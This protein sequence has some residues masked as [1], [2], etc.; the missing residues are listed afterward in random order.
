MT[1]HDDEAFAAQR[2]Q[3]ALILDR[4]AELDED[5]DSSW[6][7]QVLTEA[8]QIIERRRR[9]Y[10]DAIAAGVTPCPAAWSRTVPCVHPG[11]DRHT[12][13]CFSAVD[14]GEWPRS[15]SWFTPEA[16]Q[17]AATTHPRPAAPTTA[18]T[19]GEVVGHE[20]AKRYTAA[21]ASAADAA[22]ASLGATRA[23]LARSAVAGPA[24]THLAHA[25]DQAAYMATA[26]KS[27]LATLTGHDSI[28]EAYGSAPDAGGKTWM[29]RE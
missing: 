14:G 24:L 7:Q 18:A 28:A 23:R 26:L 29:T 9:A 13:L 21:M 27:A 11:G 4:A 20:S 17:D 16:G 2:H 25:Q 1:H 6:A 8:E 5:D 15:T 22:V 3:E 12:G 19:G 10:A